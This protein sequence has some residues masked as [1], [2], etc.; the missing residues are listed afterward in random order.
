MQYLKV[1]TKDEKEMALFTVNTTSK[2]D[3]LQRVFGQIR[4]FVSVV[5]NTVTMYRAGLLKAGV[6]L[7]LSEILVS[8]KRG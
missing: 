2:I 4:I 7:N 3:G 5:F 8:L 6:N 1:C